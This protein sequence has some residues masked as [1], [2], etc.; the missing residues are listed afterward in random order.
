MKKRDHT[1]KTQP[2]SKTCAHVDTIVAIVT[3]EVASFNLP[4]VTEMIQN[5]RDPFTVLIST[6]L[7]LRTK[8]KTTRTATKRLFA[9]A[10]TPHDMI[11]LNPAT[12]EK[13]IY[14]VGFYKNKAQTIAQVC[15]KLITEYAGT[16]PADID[17]LLT[18]PGVGRKTA[19]LVRTLGFNKPGICVDIHVHRISN[20]LGWVT[21]KNP[22]ETEMALRASLPKKYWI[23]IND[24]LVAY[25]QNICRPVSPF[26][27]RC[28]IKRYC[29]QVNVTTHR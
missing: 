13:L 26:C 23:A 17:S 25:G 15:K 11:K 22:H 21:T 14:P 12:I 2:H 24:L 10:E 8:D 6:I 19:N 28:K 7:S 5:K 4:I 3:Q 9:R 27:S 16:V 1:Q 18:F 20:R 29:K